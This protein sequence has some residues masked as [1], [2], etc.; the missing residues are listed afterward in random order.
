MHKLGM[1]VIVAAERGKVIV[2]FSHGGKVCVSSA[3]VQGY[4]VEKDCSRYLLIFC[5]G[6][7]FVNFFGSDLRYI[8][9][10][11]LSADKCDR[12]FYSPITFK[13]GCM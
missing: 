3:K 2:T 1:I 4:Y 9:Y 12:Q 8:M 5:T 7:V 6:E 13:R 10:C 11:Y